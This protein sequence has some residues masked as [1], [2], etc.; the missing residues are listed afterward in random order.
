MEAVDRDVP[1]KTF[2][3][4]FEN[5]ERKHFCQSIFQ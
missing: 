2:L 4:N 1:L 5:F 3:E